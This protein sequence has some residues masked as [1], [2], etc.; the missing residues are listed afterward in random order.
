MAEAP[1]DSLNGPSATLRARQRALR[2]AKPS[3]VSLERTG[4]STISRV[5]GIAKHLLRGTERRRPTSQEM[6]TLSHTIFDRTSA[7]RR[8][9][10]AWNGPE[11]RNELRRRVRDD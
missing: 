1:T 7:I 11:A 5:T 6:G 3:L 9:V 8:L 4:Q 10:V 2:G